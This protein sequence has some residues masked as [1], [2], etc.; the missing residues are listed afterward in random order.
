VQI[1]KSYSCFLLFLLQL[2]VILK[3]IKKSFA[4]QKK[5]YIC[6]AFSWTFWKLFLRSGFWKLG[7]HTQKQL[8]D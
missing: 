4:Y 1:T 7:S 6:H 3:K 2:R 8:T 5:N